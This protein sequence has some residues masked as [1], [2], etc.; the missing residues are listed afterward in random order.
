[1]VQM[2]KASENYMSLSDD[3]EI[4]DG[5]VASDVES[6]QLCSITYDSIGGLAIGLRVGDV[7]GQWDGYD[8]ILRTG[9]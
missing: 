6:G 9:C 1:M 5:D 8:D 2:E 3:D 7:R 4:L